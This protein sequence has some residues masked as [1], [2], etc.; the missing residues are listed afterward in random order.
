[1][2]L[3]ITL[4]DILVLLTFIIILGV[5]VSEKMDKTALALIG[6]TAVA[7]II[8]I[9]P[10]EDAHGELIET[11]TLLKKLP[12][13]T[14]LFIFFMMLIVTM[15]SRSGLFQWLAIVAIQITKGH[16]MT[17]YFAFIILT[18][19]ISFFFD[20]VTTMLILAPLTI[21]IMKV[22]NRDFRPYLISEAI[23]A[24]FGSIPSL[25]GSVPNI[26]IGNRADISF[27]EFLVILGP[28]TLILLITSIPVFLLFH[29][30]I[31]DEQ[32]EVSDIDMRIFA[33]D[34]S[35]LIKQK[36]TFI[37]SILGLLM[38]LIGFTI[39]QIFH[40][41]PVLTAMI[42]MSFLLYETRD[43][44]NETLKELQWGTIFFIVG[45]LIIVQ[46]IEELGMI[47]LTAELIEPFIA[48]V[49]EF[50]GVLMIIIGGV[51][52]GIVDNIPISAALAPLAVTLGDEI[53]AIDG[54][55]LGLALIVGVN[56]GGYLTPIASPANILALSYSEKEHNPISF[57]EFAKLGTTL[58]IIHLIISSIYFL[59]FGDLINQ[60]IKT[61]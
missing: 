4:T 32:H 39:G 18:F 50:G 1:M 35:I 31:L 34:T 14:V 56:V 9:F 44:I 60:L 58:A 36:K 10:Q 11:S 48:D 15:S 26:V 16:P 42:V 51:L 37:I 33:L 22:L 45:L 3:E 57:I 49:P 59:I 17:L 8:Y 38:L 20:T 7:V 19:V 40:M 5:L 54:K 55:F 24:N 53:P 52:S 21:E 2:S 6:A 27:V 30:K 13:D 28:L 23:V 61:L 25:V 43:S 29:K 47:E 41:S 12:W 46:A